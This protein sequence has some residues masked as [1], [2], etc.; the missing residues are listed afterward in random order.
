MR[1]ILS[2]LGLTAAAGAV[3][4]PR[5]VRKPPTLR[6]LAVPKG[7]DAP[8]TNTVDRAKRCKRLPVDAPADI[9]LLT[10]RVKMGF[11]ARRRVELYALRQQQLQF[12][13]PASVN[14]HTG[15]PHE[16][17]KASIRRMRQMLDQR[18]V[19]A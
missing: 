15:L 10:H 7:M 12:V 17:L 19:A 11:K 18:R 8:Q 16:H 1:R 5:P 2:A 4:S 3:R 13:L 14:R 6:E 9:R